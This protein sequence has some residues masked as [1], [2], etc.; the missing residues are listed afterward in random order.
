[1]PKFNFANRFAEEVIEK[2]I[3]YT[4]FVTDCKSKSRAYERRKF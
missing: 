1:M 4:S 3:E 2:G